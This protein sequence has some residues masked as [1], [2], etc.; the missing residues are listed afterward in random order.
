MRVLLADS[1]AAFAT[2]ARLVLRSESLV[3]DV[4]L[5]ADDVLERAVAVPFDA[6]VIEHALPGARGLSLLKQLRRNR[7]SAPILL[8]VA[9]PKPE[10]RIEALRFGADDCLVKPVLLAELAARVHAL[11]RRAGR[12]AGSVLEVEDLVLHCDQRRA[13]RSGRALPL[14]DREFI[15]LEHLVR[16]HGKPVPTA[17]LFDFLWHD[18]NAPKANFVA[19]LMMRVRRKVDDGCS[20]KLVHTI[21]GH[22]YAIAVLDT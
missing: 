22:G 19:V 8:L 4:A 14:T 15:A 16:A 9:D 5:T 11:T 3:V 21:R 13:F 2:A 12:K 10:A 6:L 7:V 1:D 20:M 18:K 17:E